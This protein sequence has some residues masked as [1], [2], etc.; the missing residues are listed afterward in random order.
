VVDATAVT[1]TLAKPS[2]VLSGAMSAGV[3]LAS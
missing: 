1:T 3:L 2:P